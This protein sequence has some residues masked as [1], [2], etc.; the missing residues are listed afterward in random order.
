MGTAAE[1]K[2]NGSSNAKNSDGEVGYLKKENWAD[3]AQ[4]LEEY[5]QYLRNNGVELDAI[6]IQNEPDWPCSYAGCLW[7]E[8]DMAEFVK[9]YGSQISCKVITPEP[10][11]SAIPMPMR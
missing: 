1:W 4:Y 3:Y 9:T 6:S 10:S 11:V 2:T 5:V 8:S 7:S